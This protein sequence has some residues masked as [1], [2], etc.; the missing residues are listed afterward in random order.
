MPSNEYCFV[1]RWRLRADAREVAQVIGNGPDLVRW[2]P[3]VYLEARE[4]EPGD[5]SGVGKVI[6]LYTKGWLPY[7]LRWRFRVTEV[8]YERR[9]ALE[10]RGD[11]VGT[12]VWTFEQEGEWALVTYEWN[13][14]AEKPLLR[15]LSPLL[16]P[17]FAANHHWAMRMGERSLV[18]ELARRRAQ[19]PE[20]LARI[21]PPPGPT[22]SSPVPLLTAALALLGAAYPLLRWWRRRSGVAPMPP[23]PRTAGWSSRGRSRPARRRSG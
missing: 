19:T 10:A 9:F 14:R 12:G 5:A 7:T 2:W 17:I 1:T 15:R 4:L 23:V 22:S 3:S 18:L 13:V 21:P 8:Q 16:K 6:D 20:E 11:F